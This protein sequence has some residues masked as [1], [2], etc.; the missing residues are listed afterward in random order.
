MCEY[1][2]IKTTNSTQSNYHT[3]LKIKESNH[4]FGDQNKSIHSQTSPFEKPAHLK[5]QPIR[6]TSHQAIPTIKSSPSLFS[7]FKRLTKERKP[8]FSDNTAQAGKI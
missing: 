3:Q 7:R 6:K 1:Q 5:N 2:P 8:D 4:E